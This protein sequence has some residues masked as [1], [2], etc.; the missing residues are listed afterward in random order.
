MSH[1]V[2]NFIKKLSN[3][4]F[5]CRLFW[6]PFSRFLSVQTVSQLLFKIIQV[7]MM[8]SCPVTSLFSVSIIFSRYCSRN[9][10]YDIDGVRKANYI[11]STFYVNII[12]IGCINLFKP[13]TQLH[14]LH[15]RKMPRSFIRVCMHVTYERFND[16]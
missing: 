9:P 12:S 4:L 2:I 3:P 11:N 1:L 7:H 5:L 13:Q 10:K 14:P 6:V 16:L 8:F 15:I